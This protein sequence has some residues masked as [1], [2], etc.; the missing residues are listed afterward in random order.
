MSEI[1]I[2][3]AGI[4]TKI[5]ERDGAKRTLLTTIDGSDN[6]F[7]LQIDN[8][9]LEV[10]NA[11]P[12]SAEYRL[13]HGRVP[14]STAALIYGGWIHEG[15]EEWY[16]TKDETLMLE[17]AMEAIGTDGEHFPLNEWR[18]PDRCMDTLQRY[19]RHYDSE[20]FK[21]LEHN[22]KPAV[23]IPFSLPLG[24]IPLQCEVDPAIVDGADT[25]ASPIYVNDVHVYW[26]GKIDLMIHLDERNWILDHKTSSMVGPTFWDQFSLSNQT[27]GY[28][29]AGEQIYG[30][31]FAGLVVNAIVG[32]KQTRT[33]IPTAFERQR[34]YY[35]P[36]QVAEWEAN[37][38][39]LVSDFLAN[40]HRNDFPMTT[41]WCV[42][43]Y[44]KCKYHGVCTLP[45]EQRMLSLYSD[46]FVDNT[47]SPLND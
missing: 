33:G 41:S 17:K 28:C 20:P 19:V 1:N 43:K 27:I 42:G 45:K 11:C 12:R 22:G 29:W 23:E 38:M 4:N 16:R 37:T 7:A 34:F 40:L 44:G 14:A 36:D 24:V 31:K 30:S 8:T 39:T 10:F 5:K 46:E 25:E 18:T 9:S 47:W 26:T 13:V 21:L 35:R 3:L 2:D 15:L 32:R 6:D